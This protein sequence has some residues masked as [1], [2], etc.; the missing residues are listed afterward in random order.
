MCDQCLSD[1]LVQKLMSGLLG[2]TPGDSV[3]GAV[4]TLPGGSLETGP[5]STRVTDINPIQYG[6]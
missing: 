2:W 5:G 6:G 3:R 4:N 1:H